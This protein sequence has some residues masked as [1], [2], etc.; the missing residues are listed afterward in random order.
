MTADIAAILAIDGIATGAVYALVAI[1][2]SA[3][4][5]ALIHWA[6]YRPNTAAL[7]TTVA[8]FVVRTL[9]IRF[10]WRTTALWHPPP[11]PPPPAPSPPA[12]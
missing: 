2:G 10:N 11:P 3:L 7:V 4:F 12:A 5:V 8:V 1:G 6:G 9:A